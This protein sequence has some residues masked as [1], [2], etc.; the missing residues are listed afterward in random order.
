MSTPSQLVLS[1]CFRVSGSWTIGTDTDGDGQP[2]VP[3]KYSFK[4]SETYVEFPLKF[5]PGVLF[6]WEVNGTRNSQKHISPDVVKFP[7]VGTWGICIKEWE[8]I[9]QVGHVH[10]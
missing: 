1:L 5:C 6:E 3:L 4:N 2:D 7:C 9:K 10:E 8:A